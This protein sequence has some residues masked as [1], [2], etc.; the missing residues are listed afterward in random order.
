MAHIDITDQGLVVTL[1]GPRRL[2]GRFRP[3]TVPW[4]NVTEARPGFAEARRFPGVRWGMSSYIPGTLAV[5]SFR[6]LTTRDFWD[7]TKPADT[8]VVALTG[9]KYDR[10]VLQVDD[11][12]A[13]LA[14]LARR[15]PAA[16][17]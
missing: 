13:A 17:R 5:G 6:T 1:S 16:R 11:P 10:L 9:H 14:A 8:I 7:V 3:L 15:I 4:H 2:I 12:E